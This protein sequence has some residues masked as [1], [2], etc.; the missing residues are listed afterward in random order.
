METLPVSHPDC[1]ETTADHLFTLALCQA[2]RCARAR[3][4]EQE[5][6]VKG[7]Q[8]AQAGKVT[9]LDNGSAE[10]ASQFGTATY[11]VN[12]VCPCPD[13]RHHAGSP[14][15]HRWSVALAKKA[16]RMLGE[17]VQALMGDTLGAQCPDCGQA[18][19]IEVS[20]QG[21]YTRRY[22]HYRVCDMVL[23][24]GDEQYACGWR[25]IVLKN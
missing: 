22:A 13:A 10:V 8:L 1:Q 23:D 5:R 3:Y 20:V 18:T 9:L 25:D 21:E 15:K 2:Y 7:F 14:C 4:G 6:M 19:V 16:H 12:G 11:T 24:I 17:A